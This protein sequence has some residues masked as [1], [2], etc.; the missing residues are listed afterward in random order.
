MFGDSRAR[1]D[2]WKLT[3][4]GFA[5]V[6]IL[7]FSSSLA[8]GF[9]GWYNGTTSKHEF[10]R[11]A[12]LTDADVEKVVLT[13]TNITTG[14]VGTGVVTTYQLNLTSEVTADDGSP[15][16][17]AAAAVA[18]TTR[19]TTGGIVIDISNTTVL[20]TMDWNKSAH[21]DIYFKN[22]TV[23]EYLRESITQVQW[24][25]EQL[26]IA[27]KDGTNDTR[28]DKVLQHQ[29][30]ASFSTG[31]VIFSSKKLHF[32]GTSGYQFGTGDYTVNVSVS[33]KLLVNAAAKDPDAK[34]MVRIDGFQAAPSGSDS[35]VFNLGLNVP[36]SKGRV[37]YDTIFMAENAITGIAF[38]GLGI[39]VNPK[40]TA[41]DLLG[42]AKKD[43][44]M[45]G[46]DL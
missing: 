46:G 12:A 42:R 44:K 34:T 21:L 38:I 2:Q 18:G 33:P 25:L 15:M 3:L 30:T 4:G 19:T 11:Y 14:V 5:A 20:T 9:A 26:D 43:R 1:K 13:Y 27:A 28:G 37:G 17:K 31:N 6:L 24:G 41:S 40:W 16:A 8:L 45:K 32:D 22:A 29:V 36:D 23:Q 10:G 35:F 39:V 7:V